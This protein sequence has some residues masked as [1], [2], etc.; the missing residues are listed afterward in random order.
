MNTSAAA[1]P[2]NS[3]NELVEEIDLLGNV[4][5][6]VPRRQMRAE[7]LCHRS[8]FI[9]VMSENGDL[10]VHRRA[11]TKDIWPGQGQGV[12]LGRG[13]WLAL[14][15]ILLRRTMKSLGTFYITPY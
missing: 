9:A 12:G 1:H 6:L 7:Q 3:P 8:V 5:R 11:E 10:L 14:L 13:L 2:D 4:L 15:A